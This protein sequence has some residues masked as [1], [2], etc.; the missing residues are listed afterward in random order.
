MKSVVQ[1]NWLACF[2][3]GAG[4]FVASSAMAAETV[5]VSAFA[6]AADLSTQ[7]DRYLKELEKVAAS[8]DE[9]KDAELRLPKDANT[10][11][12]VALSL[13]L[14]DEANEYK[15]NAS[16][17]IKA[18]KELAVAKDFAGTKKAI[19]ALEAAAAGKGAAGGALK[20]DKEASL[21]E[22]MKAVPNINTKLKG[23]LKGTRFKSKA[24][25]SQAL[26][27]T[28]AAIGQ[29]SAADHSVTKN[30]DEVAQWEKFCIQMR[31]AAGKVNQSIHAGDAKAAEADMDKLTVA[32]D[33]CHAVFHKTGTTTAT[34]K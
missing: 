28:I 23:Y 3:L 13:G 19:A 12:V 6:P 18:A 30:A 14:H 31:D 25:D 33:D 10:I 7:M 9:Y 22:L 17:I 1:L 2:A 4:L 26:V 24:K 27:A 15:K 20:W 11:I 32:C 29:A 21:P 5:Q 34:E 16:A 8:E